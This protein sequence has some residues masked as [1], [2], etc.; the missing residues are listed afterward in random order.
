ML[1]S[2]T[3][4]TAVLHCVDKYVAAAATIALLSCQLMLY[5]PINRFHVHAQTAAF[6]R[7]VTVWQR[8][9]TSV[10]WACLCL[11]SSVYAHHAAGKH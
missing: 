10:K 4:Y 8:M 9:D 2:G 7:V 5:M 6:H 1:I 11:R 3:H